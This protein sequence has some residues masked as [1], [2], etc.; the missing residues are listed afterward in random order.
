MS[1]I[2]QIFLVL[3]G[4]VVIGVIVYACSSIAFSSDVKVILR[5]QNKHLENETN[6][7]K[8]INDQLIKINDSLEMIV[9]TM[10]AQ[11]DDTN[12]RQEAI[13]KLQRIIDSSEVV[14]E[15]NTGFVDGLQFCIN[16]LKH[17][18]WERI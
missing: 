9:Y 3:T 1:T 5:K 6:N 13:D 4:A 7:T 10:R 8:K 2:E 17:K 11:C 12:Y 14:G 16:D 15:Y 18:P